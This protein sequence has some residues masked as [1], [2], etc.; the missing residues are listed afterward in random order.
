MPPIRGRML[1][2]LPVSAADWIPASDRSAAGTAG[3]DRLLS[4]TAAER[5]AVGGGR[6]LASSALASG[7][8]TVDGR[9]G[10]E[11]CGFRYPGSSI[12]NVAPVAG[13]RLG[14][15]RSAVRLDDRSRDR[16]AEAAPAAV[17]RPA[18]IEAMEAL[19]DLLELVGRDPGPAVGLP[20]SRAG[21]RLP[22]RST[23]TRS[24]ASVWATALRTRLRSTW[25]SRSGSASS[26]P[27]TGSS[28]SHAR[29]TAADRG[30]DPRS[31]R[32]ARSG[33]ARRARR[34]R[35]SRA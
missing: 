1:L 13:H 19:E 11:S 23:A 8:A 33:V 4:V 15:D 18:L 17:A 35:R 5:H 27:A 24:P 26:V 3:D 14:A 34:P 10:Y 25:V 6:L 30:G 31:T 7:N 12:R 21:C 2:V 28:G 32:R 20:R 16:E 29:R 22:A 9:P